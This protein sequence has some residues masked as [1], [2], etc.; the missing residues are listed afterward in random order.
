MYTKFRR[1]F[2]HKIIINNNNKSTFS[3]K[4]FL[5]NNVELLEFLI[6]YFILYVW[7]PRK[8]TQPFKKDEHITNILS[9]AVLKLNS[10]IFSNFHTHSQALVACLP[11]LHL[12]LFVRYIFN[13]VSL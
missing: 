11:L 6:M 12:F 10:Q 7:C 1:C 2:K 3:K 4:H 5:Q 13:K 9:V 8:I